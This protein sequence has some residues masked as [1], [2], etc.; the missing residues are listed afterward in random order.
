M[1]STRQSSGGRLRLGKRRTTSGS[2]AAPAFCSAENE[3]SLTSRSAWNYR[4]TITRKK[5]VLMNSPRNR[6][7]GSL[8][9]AG[10]LLASIALA[11]G[12][13][14]AAAPPP[15]MKQPYYSEYFSVGCP[16][17]SY[18]LQLRSST[19]GGTH[20]LRNSGISGQ[21]NNGNVRTTRTTSQN[22]WPV[23][24]LQVQTF[25]SSGYLYTSSTPCVLTS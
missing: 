12:G 15:I 11:G 7:L 17:G 5:G 22:P 2:Q 9:L 3:N 13:A 14:A 8:V 23:A 20:H 16:S 18:R 6:R 19:T 1:T 24:L 10:A 25:G 21:W 4:S